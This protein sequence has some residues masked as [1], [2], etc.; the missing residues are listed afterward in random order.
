MTLVQIAC[1]FIKQA[2]KSQPPV[3][4][5]N[6]NLQLFVGETGNALARSKA[7]FKALLDDMELA[8]IV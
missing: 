1:M 4:L 7:V 5:H 3:R 6:Y 2:K 8:M